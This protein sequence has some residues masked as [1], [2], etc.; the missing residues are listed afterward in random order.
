MPPNAHWKH[1]DRH[2]CSPRC[3]H[4]VGRRLNRQIAKGADMAIPRP[5]PLAD[6]RT[7]AGPR[8]FRTISAA[9]GELP[10]EFEGFGPRAGDTVERFGV[11][12][13]YWW[14]RP[15]D[16]AGPVAGAPHGV[17]VASHTSG[18]SFLLAADASGGWAELLLG[19][20]GPDGVRRPTFEPFD[21]EGTRLTWQLEHIRD[22]TAAGEDY[23][24][25]AVVCLPV[26]RVSAEPLWSTAYRARSE[27]RERISSSTASHG[28]RVRL[29]EATIERFDPLEVFERD[30]WI[31]Q[32]CGEPVDQAAKHPDLMGPS[33]DHV[34][35]LIAGG[36]HSRANSQ[37][38]HW[39]C[40][41]RKGASLPG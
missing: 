25:K 13:E 35:P 19:D 27:Q 21:F 8:S 16:L 38:A 11:T 30:G 24:W 33:L 5:A 37:L 15:G 20:I 17:L 14:L 3:N 29:A 10:F 9:A 7:T 36:D 4:N 41:V 23:T 32:L 12:V 40:N 34:I 26:E 2:V 1:R 18:H 6:P 22:L 28:R 31:C 39:I